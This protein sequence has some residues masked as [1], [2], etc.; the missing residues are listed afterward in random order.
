MRSANDSTCDLNAPHLKD[1]HARLGEPI[2]SEE[3][4]ALPRT[5]FTEFVRQKIWEA[6]TTERGD[7]K[8]NLLLG[9]DT[10]DAFKHADS[11]VS[12]SPIVVRAQVPESVLLLAVDKISENQF[13]FGTSQLF[14]SVA[15]APRVT[16]RFSFAQRGD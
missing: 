2:L 4:L 10:Q 13:N 8:S 9:T 15:V 1:V 6:R 3:Y 11:T 5:E 16:Q 14:V 7:L 12:S